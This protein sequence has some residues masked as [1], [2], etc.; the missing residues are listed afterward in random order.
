MKAQFIYI[1][2]L[3]GGLQAFL[4]SDIVVVLLI[5]AILLIIV[6][7]IVGT[8]FYYETKKINRIL[9]RRAVE[10][11][12]PLPQT[13]EETKKKTLGKRKITKR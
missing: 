8:K 3:P 5:I 2:D 9:A 6:I 11:T 13:G 12:K 10:R 7:G 4:D 1:D